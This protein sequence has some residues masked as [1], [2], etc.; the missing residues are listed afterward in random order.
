MT[1]ADDDNRG[2]TTV[3]LFGTWRRAYAAVVVA[4]AVDVALLYAV[5][6]LLS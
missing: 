1:P 2:E 6:R 3:P 4:L 5:T